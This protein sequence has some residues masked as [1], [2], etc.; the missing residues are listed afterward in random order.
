M[1]CQPLDERNLA[2]NYASCPF[3]LAQPKLDGV[4][5]WVQW[6]DDYPILWSSEGNR[7]TG[8]P[9]IAVLLKDWALSLGEQLSFDGELYN[10]SADFEDIVSIV[11]RGTDNLR[12]DFTSMQYHIFDI[13]ERENNFNRFKKLSE[14]FKKMPQSVR[15]AETFYI[16]PTSA[17]ARESVESKL[18]AFISQGYEGI[19]LRNPLATYVEKR[20]YTILKWKPSKNDLYEIVEVFEAVD[21]SGRY[22]GRLGAIKCRDRFGNSFSVGPGLG[23]DHATAQTMWEEREGLVGKFAKVYYQNL[24]KSGVPR[25]GKFSLV[26]ES[27]ETGETHTI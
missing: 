6:I 23:I 27:G 25:F 15:D 12:I 5:C 9:H 21:A 24:T 11:K 26:V 22:L 18:E 7:I 19:I 20:P 14:A 4:R 17:V 2:R 10:H 3:M 13:K 8:V 1:L 16:V